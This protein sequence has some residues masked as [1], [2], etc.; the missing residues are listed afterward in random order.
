MA[1]Y[2]GKLYVGGAF[3]SAGGKPAMNIAV[4]DGNSWSAVGEGLQAKKHNYFKGRVAALAVYKN[5]LYA[6]GTFDFSGETKLC[7]L[8]RLKLDGHVAKPKPTGKKK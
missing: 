7:N 6:G 3:D 4:W 8:A 5:E 2:D 1:V